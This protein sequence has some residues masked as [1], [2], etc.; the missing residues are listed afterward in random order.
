M[1]QGWLLI[2]GSTVCYLMHIHL[3]FCTGTEP[4][5]LY[6][7]SEVAESSSSSGMVTENPSTGMLSPLSNMNTN[8]QSEIVLSQKESNI[9]PNPSD[10]MPSVISQGQCSLNYHPYHDYA[11]PE[12]VLIADPFL[13]ASHKDIENALASV[14][15]SEGQC[16]TTSTYDSKNVVSVS[17]NSINVLTR[18]R[19]R[20][21]E[22]RL[23][24]IRKKLR[25]NG[26]QYTT[27]TGSIIPKRSLKL[28]TC[29]CH[30]K[31]ND[32]FT[33]IERQTVH[34]NYW[35]SGVY[36]KQRQYIVNM[37]E[38]HDTKRHLKAAKIN[39]PTA[40]FYH[41][42][43]NGQRVPVCKQF[44]MATLDIGRKTVDVSLKKKTAAGLVEADR[45]GK[46][47][48]VHK[49]SSTM[50]QHI[51]DDIDKY[52]V[53]ESHYARKQTSRKFL[54]CDLSIRKMHQIYQQVQ[55][56]MGKDS[57]SESTYR[58]VFCTCYNYSFH[59]PKKDLC[60]TCEK[61]KNLENRVD[62]DEVR[63]KNHIRC[64]NRAREEKERDKITASTNQALRSVTFDLQ[65]VL[66]TPCT[67]V[68]TLY[69]ARKLC[70]Y[71]LT[72][73]EQD[74]SSGRC[75][76]WDETQ[77][78]RG[79]CEI[80][81]CI[82]H[83]IRSLPPNIRHLTLYSDSCSGQNKNKNMTTA[84]HQALHSSQALESVEHKFLVPG[85][86]EME[87]DSIHSAIETAKKRSKIHVP[88][89]WYNII[90]MARRNKPYTTIPLEYPDFVDFKEMQKLIP[91]TKIDVHGKPIKWSKLTQ[92]R[93]T[94]EEPTM[95]YAKYD[96]DD[97]EYVGINLTQTPQTR[98]K[99]KKTRVEDRQT[100]SIINLSN[101]HKYSRRIEISHDKKQSLL[102]LCKQGVIPNCYLKYYQ[103]LPSDKSVVD[104][105]P[106]PDACEDSCDSD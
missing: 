44:F 91:N 31:C 5:F 62:A 26:K 29:K 49:M 71:N 96:F 68:S 69:Y 76:I 37:I 79:S 87:V 90:R 12:C 82:S 36:E 95:M 25:N 23:P 77:G 34:T 58:K 81:T 103:S 84:L 72:I 64:K 32:H 22:N 88:N 38:E 2:A 43:K 21:D 16:I 42:P 19:K 59:I 20:N 106:E 75:Y 54:A 104:R 7:Y 97:R 40:R 92:I 93:F 6:S 45:R 11:K 15:E 85:H 86:T 100:N 74:T 65:Q 105:L 56:D 66:H 53:M 70:V 102:L 63:Q 61:Y 10:M 8:V 67:Q 46:H 83:Y 50:L 94:K 9:L 60:A 39:R 48:P 89:D 24:N 13:S 52:P 51:K 47:T 98:Q 17:N 1:S 57:V 4:S 18:K 101:L 35:S 78:K 41:L 30:H 55:K 3:F 99:K 73:Y 33:E 28:V 80:A 27:S 14:L